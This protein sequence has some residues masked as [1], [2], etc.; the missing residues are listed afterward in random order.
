MKMEA[1]TEASSD[2]ERALRASM[3]ANAMI[4]LMTAA[5]LYRADGDRA[6]QP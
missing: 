4:V 3:E 2:H 1:S 5:A 6:P